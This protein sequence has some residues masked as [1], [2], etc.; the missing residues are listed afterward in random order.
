MKTKCLFIASVLIFL[1]IGC[2]ESAPP[3]IQEESF[4]Y[5]KSMPDDFDFRLSYGIYE[6]QLVDTF[7]DVVVKD[8]VLDGTVETTIQLSDED[9]EAIYQEMKEIRVMDSLDLKEPTEF[10]CHTEPHSSSSWTI[11]MNGETKRFAYGS[12]CEYP[13][14]VRQLFKLQE[15]IDQVVRSTEEYQQLPDSDGY[16]E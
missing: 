13:D 6:K 10:Q 8:L 12:F 3:K 7:Q 11:H 5:P 1:T 16:Y 15:F 9:M 2:S 14:D 4:T